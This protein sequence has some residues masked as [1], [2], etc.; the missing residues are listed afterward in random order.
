MKA[1]KRQWP[2]QGSGKLGARI[3]AAGPRTKVKFL[4]GRAPATFDP[5]LVSDGWLNSI[6]VPQTNLP[7][8]KA[9]GR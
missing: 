1:Q 8:G 7:S 4:I 5:Q 9:G 6:P 3:K 2:Q